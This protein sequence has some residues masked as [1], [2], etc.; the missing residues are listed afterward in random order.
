MDEM[1]TTISCDRWGTYN[2]VSSQRRERSLYVRHA[3][4]LVTCDC[5]AELLLLVI[6]HLTD[7]ISSDRYDDGLGE[8]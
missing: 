8:K 7:M 3:A 2:T 4:L 6:Y 5:L 1:L